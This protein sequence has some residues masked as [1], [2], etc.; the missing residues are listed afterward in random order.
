M[1]IVLEGIPGS[2]KTTVLKSFEKLNYSIVNEI[3]LPFWFANSL[4]LW[5]WILN[6]IIKGLCAIVYLSC[7]RKLVFIDRGYLSTSSVWFVKTNN[8]QPRRIKFYCKIM[9]FLYKY[10]ITI[11]LN[12]NPQIAL[13]RKNRKENN[14]DVFSSLD[15]FRKKYNW[16]IRNRREKIY[17]I[18]SNQS[19]K[20]ICSNI[21]K[22]IS[23]YYG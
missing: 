4:G 9:R 18:N 1:V 7:G 3:I 14:E 12:V 19:P 5:G 21:N 8:M 2:G 22:I 6:D 13:L 23:N 16:L 15:A 20:S 17:I 11:V 10:P